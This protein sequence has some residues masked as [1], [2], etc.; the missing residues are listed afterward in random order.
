MKT[1]PRW[2]TLGAALF[3]LSRAANAEAFSLSGS[4]AAD[5]GGSSPSAPLGLSFSA[6]AGQVRSDVSRSL[7]GALG[8][9]F[10]SGML[11]AAFGSTHPDRV[12][13]DYGKATFFSPGWIQ[14]SLSWFGFD[15][16]GHDFEFLPLSTR[17]LRSPDR[18]YFMV[19][20]TLAVEEQILALRLGPM[21]GRGYGLRPGG[22][23]SHESASFAGFNAGVDGRITSSWLTGRKNWRVQAGASLDIYE[24][25]TGHLGQVAK[26]GV[27]ND[28]TMSGLAYLELVL[29]AGAS[30]EWALGW[31]AS[32]DRLTPYDPASQTAARNE[33]TAIGLYL[34]W[35]GSPDVGSPVAG[36]S[37]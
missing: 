22:A 7:P 8:F 14:G 31:K 2:L 16:V 36:S 35:S 15:S 21:A 4:G 26:A 13:M 20:P 29:R 37:F 32:Y 17:F 3:A 28:D 11:E 27:I 34:R 12:H 9:G 6:G 18:G 25:L 5:R 33:D 24:D 23:G 1:N 10:P 19:R 30:D